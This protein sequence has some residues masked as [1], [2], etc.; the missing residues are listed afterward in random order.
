VATARTAALAACAVALAAVS[1]RGPLREA[2]VL[3][4]P[5]LFLGAVKLV[6]EDVPSGRPAT[7]FASLTLY[8]SALILAPR[9]LPRPPAPAP[10]PGGPPQ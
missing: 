10:A 4:Y 9:L 2:A 6:V 5:A 8:G 3:V 7:L 1:R